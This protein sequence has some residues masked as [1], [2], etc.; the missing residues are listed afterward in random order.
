[1]DFQVRAGELRSVIGPNGAGK[2]TFF[3]L[4]TGVLPPSGGR[5]LFKGRDITGLPAHA[6][7]RL[8]IARSYQVTNI[9]GDLSVFETCRRVSRRSPTASG[10]TRTLTAVNGARRRSSATGCRKRHAPTSELSHG[11]Q[12]YLE[13]A[14]PQIDFLLLDEPTAGMS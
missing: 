9:F 2:T 4:I 8:G 10:A 14:S 6:V 7:S 13:S 5:I 1:V 3:H 12:R 11:E